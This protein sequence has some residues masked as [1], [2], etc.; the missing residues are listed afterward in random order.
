MTARNDW[1]LAGAIQQIAHG[2]PVARE[3]A[4]SLKTADAEM[5]IYGFIA[6][7][8]KDRHPLMLGAIAE[9]LLDA[10]MGRT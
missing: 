10:L 3:T 6:D 4:D 7:E 1:T 8:V 9:S 5:W 2:D